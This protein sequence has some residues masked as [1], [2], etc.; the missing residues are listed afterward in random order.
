MKRS[1]MSKP[2]SESLEK[3]N[4]EIRRRV[5]DEAARAPS[6]SGPHGPQLRIGTEAKVIAK[7]VK[8]IKS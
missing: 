4:P 8:R 7:P 1:H 5:S 3:Q 2:V 6:R